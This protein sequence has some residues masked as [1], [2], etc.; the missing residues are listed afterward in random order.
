MKRLRIMRGV[1]VLALLAPLAR[2]ENACVSPNAD[3]L[4]PVLKRGTAREAVE[5]AMSEKNTAQQTQK[6]RELTAC[7][8]APG[9]TVSILQSGVTFDT[10]QVLDGETKGC[11]GEILRSSLGACPPTK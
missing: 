5:A 10:V 8:V 1:A 2:A 7:G 11:M 4:Q 3:G 9:T 6:L